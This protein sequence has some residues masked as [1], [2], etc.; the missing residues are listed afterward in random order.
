MF[1]T[2]W[3]LMFGLQK[4]SW[5]GVVEHVPSHSPM[6]A[7]LLWFLSVSFAFGSL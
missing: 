3:S 2:S 4:F 5:L 7:G 6:A 1:V